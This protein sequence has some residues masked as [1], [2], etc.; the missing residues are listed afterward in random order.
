VIALALPALADDWLQWLGPSRNGVSAETGLLQQWPSEGP[1]L[2]WKATGLGAGMGGVAVSRGR[3]YTTG[4]DADMTAWLL[5]LDERDGKLLWKTQIGR[6]GNPGNFVRPH[7]PRGTPAVDGE[8]LYIL[9]QRGE[10]V[11]FTL[12][13]REVWRTDFVNDLGGIMPVWGYAESPLVDGDR[14]ICTPGGPEATV[15]ALDKQTGKPVWKCVVPEAAAGGRNQ[16]GRSGAAYASPVAITFAGQRQYLQLV[17]AA[18]VGIS[19]DGQLLWRYDR[20]ANTFRINCASPLFHDGFVFASSAYGAG[21]GLVKLHREA[22][23]SVRAEEVWFSKRLQNHHGGVVY[24]DQCL[25]GAAGGN[26]G[27]GLV[28]LDFRTGEVL[29]DEGESRPPRVPKGSILLADG[30]LYYRTE[31]GTMLLIEPSRERYLE[32]GRFEQPDRSKEPAWPHPVIANGKLYLRD[33]DVLLCYDVRA[34]RN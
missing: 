5:A 3:V 4:D 22:D 25:Y 27:G 7:G 26:E 19:A 18:L 14:L 32:R 8:R 1:P 15:M 34:H 13:G 9:S 20:P 12:E 30:R 10:L 6:G 17:G 2:A 21:G 11:C 29:W 33:Q 16:P 23:G 24:H 31:Q 28:C